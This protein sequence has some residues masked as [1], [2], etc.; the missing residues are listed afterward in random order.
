MTRSRRWRLAGVRPAIAGLLFLAAACGSAPLAETTSRTPIEE[1][2]ESG[3][4]PT[5]TTATAA[6]TS[7]AAPP[8]I[9]PTTESAAV[10]G[11]VVQIMF[12]NEVAWHESGSQA[13]LRQFER[14]ATGVRATVEVVNASGS[15]QLF[16]GAVVLATPAERVAGTWERQTVEPGTN[17]SL[18]VEF[19]VDEDLE[20]DEFSL[21]INVDESGQL[22]T[23]LRRPSFV[24]EVASLAT[25][26]EQRNLPRGFPVTLAAASLSGVTVG[27]TDVSFGD[28]RIGI[29]IVAANMR[30]SDRNLGGGSTETYLIDD[31]DNRYVLME[32]P[33]NSRLSMGR[34]ERLEGQLVFAGRVHPD[35][36]NLTLVMNGDTDPTNE[37]SSVPFFSFGPIPLDGTAPVIGQPDTIS[38]NE[39][40]VHPNTV[41]VTMERLE[42]A[43]GYS[44]ATIAVL[45][46][47]PRQTSL[48]A[49][50]STVLVDDRGNQYPLAESP[51]NE[52]LEIEGG[53]TVS[54]ALVFAGPVD[55]A[56]TS[57][58]LLVNDRGEEYLFD[59]STISPGFV[60][61]PYDVTQR[62]VP[63]LATAAEVGQIS[64]V[65]TV[66]FDARTE[67]DG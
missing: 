60:F 65:A 27:V 46:N 42:F 5:S 52:S 22:N 20:V 11:D 47:R 15:E 34:F 9:V 10:A 31:L 56:A 24:F 36:T 48:N 30:S 13:W 17:R 64:D 14:S 18:V 39:R 50:S 7:A 26:T 2:T 54:M 40:Q 21:S 53:E 67:I 63:T 43:Q 23:S 6:P 8:S 3:E 25:R 38:P 19:P 16:D 29:G 45:N 1:E 49:V 33:S 28:I 57:F 35:A 55:P 12:P 62:Q 41:E 4:S 32:Q 59:D 58:T 44:T 66:A 61:G 51:R 37:F